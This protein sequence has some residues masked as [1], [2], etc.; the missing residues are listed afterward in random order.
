[1]MPRSWH[2]RFTL[3]KLLLDLLVWSAGSALAYLA[4]FDGAIP[5]RFAA[6]FFTYFGLVLV[7]RR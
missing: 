2:L 4:R 3:P 7:A 1:M 6:S 5:S